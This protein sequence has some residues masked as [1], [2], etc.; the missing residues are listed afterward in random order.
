M[1]A[2]NYSAPVAL[3]PVFNINVEGIHGFQQRVSVARLS[4]RAIASHI[5]TPSADDPLREARWLPLAAPNAQKLAVQLHRMIDSTHGISC[6]RIE[7][8]RRRHSTNTLIP[9]HNVGPFE[10]HDGP[11]DDVEW[12]PVATWPRDAQNA[13]RQP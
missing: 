8:I 10:A 11:T 4:H 1:R 12:I 13:I 7:H 6:L 3:P 9:I 2:E 5:S